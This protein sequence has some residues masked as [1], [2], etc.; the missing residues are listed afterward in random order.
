MHSVTATRVACHLLQ[1]L[2]H[3]RRA[4]ARLLALV[5]ALGLAPWPLE[6]AN[7]FGLLGPAQA[8]DDE[9]D[10]DDDDG[11]SGPGAGSDGGP[12]GLAVAGESLSSEVLAMGL[13]A[14]QIATLEGLGY[15]VIERARLARL[16]L[17][18][19]RLQEPPV[20]SR[21]TLPRQ[22]R[23]AGLEGRLSPNH[24]YRLAQPAC[25]GQR[26]YGF[27]A[28]GWPIPSSP[29]G[30]GRGLVIGMVDTAVATG[31]PALQGADVRTRRFVDGPAAPDHGTAVAGLLVGAPG[32]GFPGL[33]PGARLVAAEVFDRD[34]IGRARTHAF[35][36][37]LALDWLATQG[38]RVVN[39]SFAGPDN[40][41]L[42]AAIR[43][44][45]ARN[46]VVAAAAGNDG[47]NAAPAY[48]AAYSSR[49]PGVL[50]VTAVDV[51]LS[52]YRRANRGEHLDLSAPGVGI[53][54]AEV[55]GP[56]RFDTGTS[57]AATFVT[58]A[59]ATLDPRRRLSAAAVG[60]RLAQRARD[61]GPAGRDPVFGHGLVQAGAACR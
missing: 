5:L 21:L 51:Q 29:S 13:G 45:V 57:L 6:P 30:C 34:W 58:A 11:G 16:Q 55:E 25:E 49:V 52:P 47:P 53:W 41:V 2:G 1:R 15:R 9:D 14:T 44:L 60:Q 59:A 61:L 18:V 24:V 12:A 56:G 23:E 43:R 33:L 19:V 38:V 8:D 7:P 36:V 4:L 32:S 22:L 48:P 3:G 39:L 20:W 31:H 54:T 50:A 37:A 10:D 26:C 42:E 35:A 27:E 40:P 17:D 46:I 28:V